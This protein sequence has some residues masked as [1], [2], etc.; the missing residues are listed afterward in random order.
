[1]VNDHKK[2]KIWFSDKYHVILVGFNK[3]I[4]Y[5]L[6]TA[7]RWCNFT[8]DKKQE[9][10]HNLI[11]SMRKY[12]TPRL[13]W[14]ESVHQYFQKVINIFCGIW[15][16]AAIKTVCPKCPL[17]GDIDCIL[18]HVNDYHPEITIIGACPFCY[19]SASSHVP[20]ITTWMTI[21]HQLR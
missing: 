9:I 21:S 17:V 4:Q 11:M 5:H 10:T 18:Q 16:T 1:M 14:N 2:P 8:P 13:V 12:N 7:S 15:V 3:R 6:N 19:G 20:K